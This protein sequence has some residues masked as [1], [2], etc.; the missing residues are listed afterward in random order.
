MNAPAARSN[1]ACQGLLPPQRYQQPEEDRMRAA[2]E[3]RRPL[4][5]L[6]C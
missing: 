2:L 3:Q 6:A 5:G 4:P 1:A